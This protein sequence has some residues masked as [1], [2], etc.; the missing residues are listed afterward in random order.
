[1][2]LN[3]I[4]ALINEVDVAFNDIPY[5]N[6]VF[7]MEMFVLA[8]Q[9]TPERAYRQIGMQL[10]LALEKIV[11]TTM[12]VQE[13]ETELAETEDELKN[14]QLTPQGKIKLELAI[15][16]KERALVALRKTLKDASIE[17]DLYYEY[18]KKFPRYTREEFERGESLYYEQRLLRQL[19][20]I[21]GCKEA[22]INMT[23]DKKTLDVFMSTYQQLPESDK[24]LMLAELSKK[25]LANYIQP[26]FPEAIKKDE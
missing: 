22:I 15:F 10:Q 14:K 21:E 7:Q 9:I 13:Q 11:S 12:Q 26:V 5:S 23:D 4:K 20:N 6:S 16:Q 8:S 1:M 17:A 24:K 19:Y 18:F 25:S 2:D 3:Q